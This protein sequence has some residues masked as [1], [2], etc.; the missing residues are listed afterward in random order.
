MEIMELKTLE[1]TISLNK[2]RRFFDDGYVKDFSQYQKEIYEGYNIQ[3]IEN[4]ES[5]TR[6]IHLKIK[7]GRYIN[8]HIAYTPSTNKAK[9]LRFRAHEETHFLDDS[10]NISLLEE[11]LM[12]QGVTID[13][14][15]ISNKEVV[16]EIG[17]IY[18][19]KKNNYCLLPF[20]LELDFDFM[21]AH[22]LYKKGKK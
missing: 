19:L 17:A 21:K 15:E 4:D 8:H 18:A 14:R 9:E 12:K 7:S 5:L 16:A 13:L 22:S 10:G 11:A 2:G 1:M 3:F 20:F 6:G